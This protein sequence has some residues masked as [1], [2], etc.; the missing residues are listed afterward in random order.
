MKKLLLIINPVAGK[1]ALRSQLIDI[2]DTFVK[3]DY[4]VTTVVTQSGEHLSGTV[5]ETAENFDLVVCCGGD[6][7]LNLTVNALTKLENPP[8][9]GYIPGGTTNDFAK[10]RGI[11]SVPLNA[12]KQIVEGEVHEID[13]GFFG[14]KAYAY[15][16]A[17]GVLSD[18]SYETPR[19]LKQNIGHAAYVLEGVKALSKNKNYNIKFIIDGEVCEGN[20]IHGMITNTRRVGGFELPIIGDFMIDDGLID[21]TLVRKPETADDATKLLNALVTQRPDGYTVIQYRCSKLEYE[22]DN[23]IPWTLDGEYGGSFAKQTV[24]LKKQHLRMV[25]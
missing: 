10:S 24:E 25:Y 15:I 12:A 3:A 18:V 5:V 13:I 23:E 1:S 6:G 22:A 4:I 16:A 14:D 20:F 9:L 17:F 7:T 21:V 2:V 11:S 19:Q 8:V